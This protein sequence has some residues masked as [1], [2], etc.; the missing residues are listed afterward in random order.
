LNKRHKAVLALSLAVA[1][2]ALLNGGNLSE[3]LGIILVGASLAYLIGSQFMLA[4]AMFFWKHRLWFAIV[5]SLAI[6]GVYGWARYDA[7]KTEKQAAAFQAKMKPIWDCESRNS[8][9]SNAD[10]E[11]EKDPSATLQPRDEYNT[12]LPPGATVGAPRKTSGP[13]SSS[14]S[15]SRRV[16]TLSETELTTTEYGSLT[17]GHI[18]T[19]ET[20]LLLI[21]AGD[22][23]KIRTAEGQIGWASS[24]HFEVVGK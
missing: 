13:H 19:G 2:L 6:G 20:A 1:G 22:N 11:C 8:Q 10:A 4:R 3:A 9:F 24:S 21:D 16:R 14:V 17:C 23:V 12:P 15:S 7:Y 5:A 18:R